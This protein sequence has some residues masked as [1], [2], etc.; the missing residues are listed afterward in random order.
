M[1]MDTINREEPFEHIIER[2]AL[3]KHVMHCHSHRDLYKSRCHRVGLLISA[4]S[5]TAY[6]LSIN[7]RM[8]YYFSLVPD[9]FGLFC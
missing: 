5:L 7:Y 2:N 1:I 6:N 4:F 8:R 3:L 9:H